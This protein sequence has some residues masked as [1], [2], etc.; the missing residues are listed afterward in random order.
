VPGYASEAI[1]SGDVGACC[2]G[3]CTEAE[4]L[5]VTGGPDPRVP[6]YTVEATESRKQHPAVEDRQVK[7]EFHP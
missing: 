4:A 2:L 3:E 1:V 7:V 6:G 5:P